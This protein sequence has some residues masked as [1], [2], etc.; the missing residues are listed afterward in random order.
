MRIRN[1]ALVLNAV[2]L[3]TACAS[4]AE[5]DGGSARDEAGFS[6]SKAGP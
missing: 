6:R 5:G 4:G 3:A 1:M 2:L